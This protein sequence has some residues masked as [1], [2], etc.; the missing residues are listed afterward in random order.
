MYCL[1]YL[2]FICKQGCLQTYKYDQ[3]LNIKETYIPT[4]CHVD[5]WLPLMGVES[6]KEIAL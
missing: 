1:R 3:S 2:L 4:K 6:E 5:I